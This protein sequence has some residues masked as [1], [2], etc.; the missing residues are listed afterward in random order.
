[1][2]N[3]FYYFFPLCIIAIIIS[4]ITFVGKI[5]AKPVYKIN[6]ILIAVVIF[7]YKLFS[8]QFVFDADGNRYDSVDWEN[9]AYE[10][11]TFYTQNGEPFR[12]QEDM[13]VAVDHPESVYEK[14]QAYLDIDG[15]LVFDVANKYKVT[16]QENIFLAENQTHVYAISSGTW[17]IHGRFR[18]P[19]PKGILINGIY[20]MPCSTWTEEE[21]GYIGLS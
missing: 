10:Q 16:L 21:Q 8:L 6:L 1:M 5:K 15:N 12:I 3:V 18:A 11:A 2:N 17:D 7:I 9:G 20:F 19:E 14:S 13:V 4:I